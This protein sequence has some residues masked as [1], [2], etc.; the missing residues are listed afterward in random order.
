MKTRTAVLALL[1]VATPITAQGV[2][3]DN[4]DVGPEPT[5][6]LAA[7][8]Q[9][10]SSELRDPASAEYRIMGIHPGKCKAGWATKD[11]DW[12]GYAATVEINAKN[13]F[14]GYTGFT[15]HTILFVG[16]AAVRI[17][18]GANFGAFGPTKGLLGLGGG[19]GVCR[20][21]DH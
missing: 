13:G 21:L 9:L 14:G 11:K 5:E 3:P 19:A 7:I 18:D 12:T 16:N 15:P 4:V 2:T 20:F 1:A 10:M 17:V 6:P 8:R